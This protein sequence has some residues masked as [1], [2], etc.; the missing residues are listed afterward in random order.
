DAVYGFV[1]GGAM[2]AVGVSMS[3]FAGRT[4]PR[5]ILGRRSS[6]TSMVTGADMLDCA[7]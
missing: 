2:K 1:I 5:K 3:S 7:T 4:R 6:S